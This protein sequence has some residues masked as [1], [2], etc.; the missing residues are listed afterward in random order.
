M[1]GQP[2]GIGPASPRVKAMDE[3]EHLRQRAQEIA[4]SL[5]SVIEGIDSLVYDSLRAQLSDP[6]MKDLEKQM[7]KARR[8]AE[9][10]KHELI[11]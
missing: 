11:S 8:A 9:K 6:T 10:C 2:F 1:L 7:A 4:V 3:R 5:D